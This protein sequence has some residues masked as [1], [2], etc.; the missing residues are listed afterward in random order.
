MYLVHPDKCN[1]VLSYLIQLIIIVFKYVSCFLMCES[2]LILASN[3]EEIY[4]EILAS[5][6]RNRKEICKFGKEI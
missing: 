4:K 1:I 5:P 6:M 3:H 2:Y